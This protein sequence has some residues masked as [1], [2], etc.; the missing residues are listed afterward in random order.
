MNKYKKTT[1][2]KG[3]ENG[4]DTNYMNIISTLAKDHPDEIG[5]ISLDLIINTMIPISAVVFIFCIFCICLI[6]INDLNNFNK[7][8][9]NQ[10]KI[11]TYSTLY[12]INT[13]EQK[14][15]QYSAG[16][17]QSNVPLGIYL[18]QLFI[19]FS[20]L[21]ISI[22]IFTI[23][24]II[25]SLIIS[26]IVDCRVKIYQP[27][28]PTPIIILGIVICFIGF[29]FTIIYYLYYYF[30]FVNNIL[31]KD[32]TDFNKKRKDVKA[33]FYQN[34]SASLNYKDDQ[35]VKKQILTSMANGDQTSF[36]LNATSWS[37]YQY[38][39]SMSTADIIYNDMLT[40][41]DPV[42][43]Q[44]QKLDPMLYIS[45][46][47]KT[48][49][50]PSIFDAYPDYSEWVANNKH[51]LNNTLN[52]INE[53][54]LTNDNNIEESIKQI[55]QNLNDLSTKMTECNTPQ[56]KKC[57]NKLKKY[58]ITN[59]IISVIFVLLIILTFVKKDFILL[60]FHE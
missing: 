39:N 9:L 18:Q 50:I 4:E 32:I 10:K 59:I 38:F 28:K 58:L 41:F 36:V 51:C 56:F 2:I 23:L 49:E 3:G 12:N 27:I 60:Y 13:Y 52:N 1:K 26:K 19:S 55:T 48:I 31:K 45:S 54:N 16:S 7:T 37:I 34:L 24:G 11:Q 15:L 46:T 47:L 17:T 57:L 33:K 43:I 35:S 42:N 44:T 21:M 20:T 6:A 29:I 25:L 5:I 53:N 22:I 40:I 30:N 8:I 14:I